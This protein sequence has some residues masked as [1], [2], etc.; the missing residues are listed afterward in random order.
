M[1]EQSSTEGARTG[2]FNFRVSRKGEF[3]DNERA[4]K[5]QR[6]GSSAAAGLKMT[7]DSTID[8]SPVPVLRKP[9]A[10]GSA[11]SASTTSTRRSTRLQQGIVKPQIKVRQSRSQQWYSPIEIVRRSTCLRLGQPEGLDTTHNPQNLRPTRAQ[12]PN[13]PSPTR[14]S[15]MWTK[16]P[17]WRSSQSKKRNRQVVCLSTGTF[18]IWCACSQRRICKCPGSSAKR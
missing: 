15:T 12:T 10:R 4:S 11:T 16:V 2:L 5:R 14:P 3:E 17:R 9:T 7:P 8:P 13:R 18:S 1:V 6:V